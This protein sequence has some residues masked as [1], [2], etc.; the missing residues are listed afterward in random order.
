MTIAIA[1]GPPALT[2]QDIRD[3]LE[4]AWQ[5][6]DFHGSGCTCCDSDGE[7]DELYVQLVRAAFYACDR[8]R[9]SDGYVGAT[10]AQIDH[11]AREAAERAM[12][13]AR[14]AI[15][16]TAAEQLAGKVRRAEQ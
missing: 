9:P 3:Q 15:T 2:E 11:L 6:Y 16:A 14:R 1:H 8:Y 4:L 10:E 5:A 7:P 12:L 13:A